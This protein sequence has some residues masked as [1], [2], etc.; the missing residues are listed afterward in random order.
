MKSNVEEWFIVPGKTNPADHCIRY[1]PFIDLN[2]NPNWITG[3]K[4][5]CANSV[6][7]F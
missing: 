4:L 2:A 7:T 5:L 6:I 3:L 1:L